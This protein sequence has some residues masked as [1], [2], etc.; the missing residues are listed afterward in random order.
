MNASIEN[1]ESRKAKI[2]KTIY[3]YSLI[4][5]AI[6]LPYNLLANSICI[7][8]LTLNWAAEG[9]FRK[10]IN[11]IKINFLPLGLFVFFYFLHLIGMLYTSNTNDGLFELQKKISLLIFPIVIATS[12]KLYLIQIKN[13]LKLFFSSILIATII[14][15]GYASYRTNLF[16]TYANP[17]W[18]HFSYSDLTA[19][20]GIQHTYLA[21]Y[22]GFSILILFY[23]AIKNYSHYGWQKKICFFSLIIYLIFFMFLLASRITIAAFMIILFAGIIYYFYKAN[24]LVK[25]FLLLGIIGLF[26]TFL[27]FQLPFMMERIKHTLGIEQETVWI[28]QYGD[29]ESVQPEMRTFVWPCARNIIEAN[30]FC[31]VGTGDVQD[32]LQI[33]YKNINLDAAYNSKY[34]A[35]NQYMET[36]LGLGVIGLFSFLS[37]LIIPFIHAFSNKNYLYL[38]FLILFSICCLTESL[39]G[40]QHGIV[41]YSFFTSLFAFH[42]LKI[43]RERLD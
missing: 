33:Q 21:L 8:L 13:I 42:S 32:A 35:H 41:F 12:D 3:Y 27:I 25:G 22:T 17:Y 20:I 31:G 6:T 4:L 9:N 40:R 38:S 34:N 30:W 28:N 16:E 10:K 18:L 37:C 2:H 1:S 26:F 7:I 19:I 15:L 11:L 39:L 36:L 24:K 29:G 14:C 43:D 5:I 23:F